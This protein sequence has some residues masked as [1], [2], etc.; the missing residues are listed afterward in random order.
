MVGDSL[1]YDEDKKI[2]PFDCFS[3]ARLLGAWQ[4]W[5][6]SVG[7]LGGETGESTKPIHQNVS[8]E[9][10][11]HVTRSLNSILDNYLQ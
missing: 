8:S 10:E 5:T 7:G 9:T 6:S 11:R 2:K 4:A 3:G 1:S